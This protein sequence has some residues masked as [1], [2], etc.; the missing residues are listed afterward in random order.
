MEKELID[1]LYEDI[2]GL[3][4]F[5]TS[6][7]PLP[8]SYV[9]IT[10]TAILRK[11]LIDGWINR[12]A[13]L[14]GAVYTFKSYDTSQVVH[15]IQNQPSVTF[16]MAAGV[17]LNGVPMRGI[18]ASDAPPPNEGKALLPID[19]MD[20]TLFKPNQLLISKRIYYKNQWIDFES[21]IRF[22]AN[23]YGGVHYDPKREHE[24]QNILEEAAKYFIA[25]NPTGLNEMQII[26]PFSDKHQILLVLP[27]EGENIWS[28]LD[29]E[30]LSAAQAFLNIHI[31]G[32][33]LIE[34]KK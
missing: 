21:I 13:S 14:T 30:L 17:Y 19:K 8:P 3:A 25:G 7:N 23:K 12:L 2:S 29:I 15:S 16:F 5:L 26:E 20:L 10:A 9:R 6:P 31:D 11:W 32:E 33:P 27:K 28:C 4:K 24:W 1:Q 34:Y 18:Y 22:V